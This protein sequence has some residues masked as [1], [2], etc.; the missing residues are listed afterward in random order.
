MDIKVTINKLGPIENS[1]MQFK[2]FMVFTGNSGVGKSYTA[3]LWYHLISSFRS[4]RLISFVCQK[5]GLKV[6]DESITENKSYSFKIKELRKWINDCTSRFLG[7][8]LGNDEFLCDVNYT[9][10]DLDDDTIIPI[11]IKVGDYEHFATYSVGNQKY[12][13]PSENISSTYLIAHGL[14]RYFVELLWGKTLLT[15]ILFPPARAA[16]MG[17]NMTSSIGMY[18]DF[19]N[20]LN[21]LKTPAIQESKDVQFFAN[22]IS[23][24]VDGNLVVDNGNVYLQI[25]KEERIPISAAASSVKEL[26]PF[27]LM[28][29]NGKT[30]PNYSMLFEEP[31]AHVHPKKQYLVMDMLARC[32][33]RGM[34]IQMTTHSDYLLSRMNQLIRLGQIK[35]VSEKVF[36]EYCSSH[37]HNRNLYLDAD[38]IGAYYFKR[39]N[40]KITIVEQN[41]SNG[42]PFTSF[43]E[44]INEQMELAATIEDAGQRVGLDTSWQ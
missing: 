27:L 32:A 16:F 28:I 39:E 9:F 21:D 34:L 2:P 43:D 14:S 36:E 7:Y 20:Q 13:F 19:L 33:N 24:L 29:Q 42:L 1:E 8:L 4:T 31:E 11:S 3:M 30:I 38:R 23:K 5:W 44:I 35:K 6:E 22:Y 40:G 25:N 10:G 18:R 41:V 12:L 26:T 15:P 37:R 17:A